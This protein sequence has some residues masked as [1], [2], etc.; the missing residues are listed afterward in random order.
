MD[1][2]MKPAAPALSTMWSQLRYRDLDEF[3]TAARAT[4]FLYVELGPVVEPAMLAALPASAAAHVRVLH[5]PCPNAGG[6]PE[7]S[8]PDDTRRCAAVGAAKRTIESAARLGVTVVVTH[9][10]EV[11]VDRRWENALRARW[12]QGESDAGAYGE[13][14]SRV[15]EMRRERAGPFLEAAQRSLSDLVPLL[16]E[17]GIRLALENGEWVSSL[18]DTQEARL[19][20]DEFDDSIGLWLDTGH[21]TILERLGLASLVEWAQLAPARLLGVHYHDVAGLRDHLIPGNGTIDWGRLAPHIPPHALPTCEFDWYYSDVEV[22]AGTARLARHG[23][24]S[25]GADGT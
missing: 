4:G 12:L 6:V 19:L 3:I 21:G 1:R 10:G 11:A 9:L 7:L 20:L 2:S 5:N 17:R 23:L 14:L 18:P 24:L 15:L 13:L 22:Q 8:D 16:R 25:W